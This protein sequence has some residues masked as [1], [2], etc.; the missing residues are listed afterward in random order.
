MAIKDLTDVRVEIDEVDAQI[1]ALFERRMDLAQDVA[2]YKQA[3]GLPVID[4]GRERA[5][6][7]EIQ[8]QAPEDL[9]S[10]AC[11]LFNLLMELS[12]ASQAYRL[13]QDSQCGKAI[14]TAL[15][16]TPAL[17]PQTAFVACQGVEGAF[18]QIACDKLF[19]HPNISYFSS[20][21]AVFRA[22]EEGLCAFGVVP[23]ENS[24]AGT[25]NQVYDL[26]QHYDFHIARTVRVKVD[27]NLLVKPGTTLET[28]TD[29]YSHAQAIEQCGDFLETLPHV[30]VHTC[31]NT[32]MAARFV[33]ESPSNTVAALGSRSCAA[34]Y[35]LDIVRGVVQ[36]TSDN[37]TRFACITKDLE[38]YPGANRATLLVTV[39]NEPGSLYKVLARF[40]SL[41][42]NLIKLESRP[43]PGRDFEFLFYFDLECDVAAPEFT[44][45]VNTLADV[46][47][48]FR[49]AGAYSEVV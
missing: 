16:A 7:A 8:K 32:A 42:I 31:E 14:A 4:R 33:A 3:H 11:V 10:G 44:K 47:E 36:N 29:I 41:D 37:Y 23:L 15:A 26:M 19:K 1:L 40:Y 25:V 9:A 22:V 24:T 45:L 12:S 6:L 5:K 48:E 27:H 43:I 46:C 28:I 2:T 49:F 30:T 18:S 34:L 21:D 20:F 13:S 35:N 39:A 17:F 38:I